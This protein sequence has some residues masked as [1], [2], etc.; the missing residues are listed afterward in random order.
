MPDRRIRDRRI[1]RR[2]TRRNAAHRILPLLGAATASAALVSCAFLPLPPE[3][4]PQQVQPTA[5][6]PAS[7]S[8]VPQCPLQLPDRYFEHVTGRSAFDVGELHPRAIDGTVDELAADVDAVC[9]SAFD[10]PPDLENQLV[11]LTGDDVPEA[12]TATARSLGLRVNEFQLDDAV[13]HASTETGLTIFALYAPGDAVAR[14]SGLADA[15]R[16][17]VLE[18]TILQE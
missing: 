18:A 15:E 4:T 9:G 3:R 16:L 5:T 6:A 8:G 12:L 17:W 14:M 11:L 13:W 7:A 2:R 10:R 1:R